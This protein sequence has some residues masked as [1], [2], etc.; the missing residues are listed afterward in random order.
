MK[1]HVASICI[2]AAFTFCHAQTSAQS[3][4]NALSLEIG[5]T[6]LIFN[7]TYDHKLRN[8]KVGF[9]AGFGASVPGN[10]QAI[11]TGGGAYA[12][13]G[14]S[15]R[16]LELGVDLHYL[17]VDEES[18]DQIGVPLVYPDYPVS[19]LYPSLNIGYRTYGKKSLFR[20]G[21]SP[22]IIDNEFVPGG[23]ISYGIRF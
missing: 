3:N 22:G 11:T 21:L 19:T 13:F 9:R 1:F 5:K 18:D 20:I 7:L 12:L 6:G 17:Y 4:L 10:L 15:A 14:S 2:I 16:F 23:Y 8:T